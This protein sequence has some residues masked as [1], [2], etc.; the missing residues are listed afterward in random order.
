L[1]YSYF[2]MATGGPNGALSDLDT[3][4]S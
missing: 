4:S 3:T 2:G 1:H